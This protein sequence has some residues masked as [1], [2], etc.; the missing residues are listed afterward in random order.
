MS[1]WQ[2][3]FDFSQTA[4][5]AWVVLCAF[6]V[7]VSARGLIARVPFRSV[8]VVATTAVAGCAAAAVWALWPVAHR[9]A[10]IT[11]VPLS[12]L[13]IWW[14]WRWYPLRW[15][16]APVGVGLLLRTLRVI[17]VLTA[18]VLVARPTLT[19]QTTQFER[20]RA[21]LLI[22]DSRSMGLPAKAAANPPKTRPPTR[23]DAVNQALRSEASKLARLSEKVELSWLSFSS[24]TTAASGPPT[25]ATGAV[26]GIAA[27]LAS[28]TADGAIATDELI[29]ITDGAE[30]VSPR[31]AVLRAAAD[32]AAAGIRVHWFGVGEAAAVT[33]AQASLA[34]RIVE[35]PRELT[36]GSALR[37]LVEVEARGLGG[38]D[39]T[40]ELLWDGRPVATE[41]L[42]PALDIAAER[43]QLTFTPDEAGYHRLECRARASEAHSAGARGLPPQPASAAQ[44]VLV[45][46]EAHR[47]LVVDSRPRH[48]L[49][50]LI[51][52]LSGDRRFDAQ[53]VL[54]GRPPEGEWSNPL[55]RTV[56]GWQRYAV[57]VLGDLARREVTRT[58]LESLREAVTKHGVG[59]IALGGRRRLELLTVEPLSEIAPFLGMP[60]ALGVAKLLRVS[61]A[62]AAQTPMMLGLPNAERIAEAWR[63]LGS[64]TTA[65]SLG[66]AKQT[67]EVWLMGDGDAPLIAAIAVGKGRC[68]A[69]GLEDTWR[70]SMSAGDGTEHH[71]RFWRQLALWAANPRSASYVETEHAIYELARLRSGMQRVSILA[72]HDT[73]DATVAGRPGLWVRAT[74][75]AT[76]GPSATRPATASVASRSLTAPLKPIGDRWVGELVPVEI[77][78]YRIELLPRDPTSAESGADIGSGGVSEIMAEARFEI[79]ESDLELAEP[80]LDLPLL[81]AAAA[82]AAPTAGNSVETSG[83]YYRLDQLGHCIDDIITAAGQKPISVEQR[84]PLVEM[85]KEALLAALALLLGA[86]WAI[87]RRMGGI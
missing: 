61:T 71:A 16:E 79:V 24:G 9:L 11:A 86:E 30:N 10:W 65:L 33:D 15:D 39:V 17:A 75:I 76:G 62:G 38:S 27:A 7:W 87:R 67:A 73:P 22:D 6:L 14:S 2:I 29:V 12:I 63:G 1:A 49:A 51:R 44:W 42:R 72:G 77:G 85:M 5:P 69:V 36:R 57:V 4:R 32:A 18:L 80:T 26:T 64:T 78:S 46:P 43:K 41:T 81:Q 19:H 21:A 35:C 20:R 54:L 47:L 45:R 3:E 40:L 53:T 58:Q 82:V 66:R 28:Q 13:V 60:R 59:L 34:I 50:F 25:M 74:R 8:R 84:W 52:S 48:E 23:L 55:P 83:R 70:W 56:E 31:E 68:V 37:A